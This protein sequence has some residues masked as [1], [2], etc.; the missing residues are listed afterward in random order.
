[1]TLV[2]KHGAKYEVLSSNKLDDNFNA[3][4]AI[5]GNELFLRG[6]THLYCIA[7]PK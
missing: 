2:I 6:G 4:P 7:R 5:V 1:M 3:S